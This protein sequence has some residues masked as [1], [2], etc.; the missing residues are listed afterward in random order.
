[1]VGL[2][3]VG[4]KMVGLK[5]VGLKMV[6]LKMVGLKMVGLKKLVKMFVEQCSY[7]HGAHITQKGWCPHG[8]V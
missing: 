3:M 4:L 1:M 2:K 7:Y 5:M 6:G 8:G